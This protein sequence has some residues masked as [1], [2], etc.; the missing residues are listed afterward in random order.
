MSDLALE[1]LLEVVD[2]IFRG[3]SN[4]YLIVDGINELNQ[5]SLELE[6][7]LHKVGTLSELGGPCK[8]LIVSRN[9]PLL[10]KLLA[11]WRTMTISSHDSLRDIAIF[12]DQKLDGATHLGHRRDEVIQRL[13]NGSKGLFLWAD[14]AVSELAHLRTWNEILALLENGNR[15]LDSTY[16]SIIKQLDTSS[17]GLCRIRAKALP[18]VAVACR[19]FRLEEVHE[20]LA[21]EVSKKFVDPGNRLLGGWSTLS[22][23]CGPFL[24]INEL[25]TIELIH[26]S[27]KDFLMSHPWALSLA[28]DNLIGGSANIEMACIC[29]SYLS[30]AVFGRLPG[31]EIEAM[32]VNSL[33]KQYP[34][35]EYASNFWSDHFLRSEKITALQLT[36]LEQ[37][38]NSPCSVTWMTTF[39]PCFCQKLGENHRTIFRSQQ[40]IIAKLKQ[41]L[42]IS[43]NVDPTLYKLCME[44]FDR[45]LLESVQYSL[46]MEQFGSGPLAKSTLEKKLR[47]AECYSV[48]YEIEAAKE[49]TSEALESAQGLLG[50]MEPLTLELQ[51]TKLRTE[52][53]IQQRSPTIDSRDLIPNFI[54]FVKA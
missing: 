46:R 39:Y 29:L 36:L 1:T 11:S 52:M 35:L 16:A 49:I 30:F 5:Q 18:L 37:F 7:F 31:E 40:S 24:Q 10:E 15:G 54:Q 50:R 6:S 27:A 14:L 26:V 2:D 13:V 45:I 9:T 33:T 17:E 4:L 3:N 22:L 20:L 38:L 21:V 53:H 48:L 8:A 25:G 41:K 43:G 51:H 28:R 34:L 44:K 32:N 42:R 47:L 12:L 23:A 19:P